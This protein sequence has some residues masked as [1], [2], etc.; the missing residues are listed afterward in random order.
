MERMEANSE[1]AC[2]IIIPEADGSVGAEEEANHH[3]PHH[4]PQAPAPTP[5]ARLQQPLSLQDVVDDF[6]LQSQ[7]IRFRAGREMKIYEQPHGQ[8]ILEERGFSSDEDEDGDDA[9]NGNDENGNKGRR[10]IV[11]KTINDGNYA[12]GFLRAAYSLMAAFVGGFLFIL[13][14][15]ILLFLFI[16]LAT[17]MGVTSNSKLKVVEV[18]AVLLSVPVFIYSLAMG[19]TLVGSFVV[20]TFYGHPFLRSFGM[21]VATTD[22]IAFVLYLGVPIISFIVTLFLKLDNWWEISLM[23]WFASILIFWCLFSACVLF[24]EIW[25]CLKLMEEDDRTSLIDE[26]P[27]R[28]KV[29]YWLKKA[30]NS[31]ART[32]KYRLSGTHVYYKKMEEGGTLLRSPRHANEVA[33]VA[34]EVTTK[35]TN[36]CINFISQT[37][38]AE[39]PYSY[40]ANKAWNPCFNQK[41]PEKIVTSN[42]VLGKTSYVTRYS[43]S[44]EK[45]FCRS[46]GL[47]STIPITK[48]ES[49]ITKSQIHSTI[50][51]N[52]LGSIM[53]VLLFASMIVW[54]GVSKVFLAM[55]LI[56]ALIY[57]ISIAVGTSRLL[58]LRDDIVNNESTTKYR[59]R[60]VYQHSTPK[61]SFV[62]A[63][64]FSGTLF[65]YILPLVYLCIRN[66]PAACL[67]AFLGIFSVLRHFLNPRILLLGDDKKDYFQKK[68]TATTRKE[69]KEW[70]KKSMLYHL[71]AIGGDT[72]RSFWTWTFVLLVI[73]FFV[74]V[75]IAANADD[76]DPNNIHSGSTDVVTLVSGY[77]YQPQP[78]LPYPTCRLKKGFG[79][80]IQL[81]DFAF[82]SKLAYATDDLATELLDKW[83]GPGVAINDV[84]LEEEF[85]KSSYYED[86]GF[87][88][89]VSYKLITFT[90]LSSSVLTIRGTMTVWDLM[91]DAQLWL[92]AMLFQ[93]LRFVVP[94]SGLW[95]PILH[96]MVWIV[97]QLESD[98]LVNVAFYRETKGFV[99]YLK[100]VEKL[101]VVVTG[102]SLGG[103]LALITGAQSNTNAVAISGPNAMISRDTFFPPVTPEDL[104]TLTFNVVPRR[105]IV[106]MIDDKAMLYQNINCNAAAN[107]FIGCHDASRSLCEIQYTCGSTDRPVLCDCVLDYGYPEPEVSATD[108]T[109]TDS[110]NTADTQKT[111]T[112]S[113]IDIC[114]EESGGSNEKC[115]RWKDGVSLG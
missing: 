71:V 76:T 56:V 58:V 46:G 95:T 6:S 29:K 2:D 43:W 111:F 45:L 15:D 82:L 78:H 12:F 27:W 21:G 16:D 103:G 97:S 59:Y 22:W 87:G 92:S 68:T 9:N 49:S 73:F 54:L 110:S 23:A 28:A 30:M 69:R 42:D 94:F 31:S 72:A 86:F 1:G 96:H 104:D 17:K 14:V 115:T 34:T 41:L 66:P 83:F 18:I 57:F 24:L 108:D 10:G 102:H 53:I 44:L 107:A 51:C 3:E 5:P 80:D 40:F 26:D 112:Q 32:T 85:K 90:D 109:T 74:L 70:K 25:T 50:T 8:L 93:G 100:E 63:I 101:E 37:V 114:Q 65:L 89:G 7:G 98:S 36:K 4:Q 35:M 11:I 33:E 61:N 79:N 13:A 62:W 106:P 84:V 81:A 113:C 105:D 75:I 39:N 52:I 47:Y 55:V 64:I 91:A 99:D 67:F 38:I 77:V 19:M 48:G 88:S 20:D 60:E